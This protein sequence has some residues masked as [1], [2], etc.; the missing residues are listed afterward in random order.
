MGFALR[1]R[2][3][4][5]FK[6]AYARDFGGLLGLR[7]AP[8]VQ[9]LRT[10]VRAIA[11]SVAPDAVMRALLAA[12]VQ[13]SVLTNRGDL[14][15]AKAVHLLRMRWRQGNSCQY[16]STHYGIKQ[17]I[18]DGATVAPDTRLV[19]NP[20][21]AALRSDR[22]D[23]VTALKLATCNAERLLARRSFRHYQDPREVNTYYAKIDGTTMADVNRVIKQYFPLDNLVFTL[24]G[25]ASEIEA[26][27]KKYAPII[28]RKS[29]S[30]PGF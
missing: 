4:E 11:E 17:I 15:A 8:C 16:L 18:Q 24:I 20:A 27:A 26:I 3:I 29:I 25:K 21:R 14:P 7:A 30:A 23:L 13:I 10:Q 22:H 28:D 6:T 9:T 5:G 1:L 12:V 19:R 2:S